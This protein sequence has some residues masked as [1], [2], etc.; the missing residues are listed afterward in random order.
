MPEIAESEFG[1]GH[2]SVVV[3]KADRATVSRANRPL[4]TGTSCGK[5]GQECY[6]H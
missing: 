4:P 2:S 1:D 3:V 6:G 5:D